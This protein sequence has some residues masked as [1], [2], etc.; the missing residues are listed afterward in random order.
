MN[1]TK[2]H[3]MHDDYEEKGDNDIIDILVDIHNKIS[4]HG[5][6]SKYAN[7]LCRIAQ[8]THKSP[9]IQQLLTDCFSCSRMFI[10]TDMLLKNKNEYRYPLSEAIARTFYTTQNGFTL[11]KFQHEIINQ[12]KKCKKL[13][14]SAPT[15]FGKSA[16]VPEI[17]QS[18]DY[19]NIAIVVPTISLLTE[20][21]SR[22]NSLDLNEKYNIVYTS[23]QQIGRYNIFI[24]TPERMDII[25]D[26]NDSLL[27]DF[28]VMDE[29]YKIENDSRSNVFTN[30]LYRLARMNADMYLIGPYFDSFSANF[31]N[32]YDVKFI[33]YS[34]E[35]VAKNEFDLSDISPTDTININDTELSWTQNMHNNLSKV[36]SALDGPNLIYVGKIPTAESVA[37][38]ISNKVQACNEDCSEL[39]AFISDTISPEWSLCKSLN[40]G[41]AFHYACM[42][43][44]IQREIVDNFNAGN[45]NTIVCTPTLIEGVNTAA[46]N[47][48]ILDNFK[49]QD[50]L[51][52]FDIKNIKGRSGRLGQHFVGNVFKL[53]QLPPEETLQKVDFILFDKENLSDEENILM[54]KSDMSSTQKKTTR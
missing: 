30:C 49:G 54:S 40:K 4:K 37:E 21:I 47:V 38:K 19:D 44:Y 11:T 50:K 16:I 1:T 33:S 25:L 8:K 36:V 22:F 18:S 27:I 5:L 46:K 45:I 31:L 39:I 32:K 15:S 3:E 6:K 10:Y 7:K 14:V 20:Y 34:Q 9:L 2:I 26:K 48:F 43:K 35:I 52:G 53:T 42:P 24:V 23:S 29:I 51:S 12:F 13:A 28:F 17:I 41:V